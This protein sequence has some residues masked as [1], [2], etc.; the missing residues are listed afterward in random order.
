MP[1]RIEGSEKL[2][3]LVNPRGEKDKTDKT[4]FLGF[5]L[6]SIYQVLTPACFGAWGS[7]SGGFCLIVS[8]ATELDNILLS[9]LTSMWKG[10]HSDGKHLKFHFGHIVFDNTKRCQREKTKFLFTWRGA[11]GEADY[12][13]TDS[14]QRG[15]RELSSQ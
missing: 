3:C 10:N 5:K 9:S 11:W 14:K 4:R 13:A 8:E 15:R 6:F 12:K 1:A 7:E 2:S